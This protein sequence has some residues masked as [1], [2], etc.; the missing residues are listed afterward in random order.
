MIKLANK[1][2]AIGFLAAGH[3]VYVKDTNPNEA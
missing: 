3:W 1:R 2:I